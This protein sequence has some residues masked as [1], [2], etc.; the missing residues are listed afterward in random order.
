MKLFLVKPLKIAISIL[1]IITIIYACVFILRIIFPNEYGSI[2]EKYSKEYGIDAYTALALVKA[3][4]NFNPDAVSHKKAKGLMQLTD[5]TFL[6]C[7]SNISL[8]DDVF[9]PENNIKA[10]IWYLS[11]LSDKFNSDITNVLASYNAGASNVK[12]WLENE[13][14]S[15]DGL[16]LKKVPYEETHNYIKRVLHYRKI[17]YLLYG[18]YR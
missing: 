13:K 17:Y 11:F 14:Y 10:G 9:N 2:I 12:K 3:E 1:L 16:S 15:P 6:F 7:K 18:Q 5:E 8:N 4:S